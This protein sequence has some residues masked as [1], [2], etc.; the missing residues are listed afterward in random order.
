MSDSLRIGAV[1]VDVA[2]LQRRLNRRGA[3][4]AVDHVF[5]SATDAAVRAFQRANGLVVDGVVGERTEGALLG[6]HPDKRALTQDDVE[7]AAERLGCDVPAMQAVTSVESPRGGFLPDGRVVILFERHVFYRRLSEAGIDPEPC[8]A[9]RPDICNP[10]PG[11]YIGGAG[12]YGRLAAAKQINESIALE[13]A[14]WGRF[15]IMGEHWQALGYPSVQGFAEQMAC[16]ELTQLIAFVEFV[17]ADNVIC[18][19]LRDHDWPAF[20]AA[21]NGPN[22]AIN[23]YDARLAQAFIAHGGVDQ[24]ITPEA[25]QVAADVSA[26][27]AEQP[28]TNVGG[29]SRRGK[30]KADAEATA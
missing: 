24:P 6:V 14:S 5:G 17:R 27:D 4:L 16:S 28:A 13:S 30:R 3:N 1:G 11:G 25:E 9:A 7:Y 12:E 21:Y 23:H 10:K 15:Q 8:V 22:Y 20:A 18:T 29:T 2:T 26:T 19:A